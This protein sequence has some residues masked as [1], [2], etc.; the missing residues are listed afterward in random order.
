M[1][2]GANSGVLTNEWKWNDNNNECALKNFIHFPVKLL[3]TIVGILILTV[4]FKNNFDSHSSVQRNDAY[5]IDSRL[6]I[7]WENDTHIF[8]WSDI[9]KLSPFSVLFEEFRKTNWKNGIYSSILVSIGSWIWRVYFV[10]GYLCHIG[11]ALKIFHSIM[12]THITRI[13]PDIKS[14]GWISEFLTTEPQNQEITSMIIQ[15]F[16]T[17][18]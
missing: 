18:C 9:A 3:W 4:A 13:E 12:G 11:I 10:S 14:L 6:W 8:S 15:V 7:I 1:L 5:E 16:T 2:S 17:N